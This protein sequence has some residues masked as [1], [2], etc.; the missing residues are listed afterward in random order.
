MTKD[1]EL[2]ESL[3]KGSDEVMDSI[4][5]A[6]RESNRERA[7]ELM[8]ESSPKIAI[9]G[10][11][12]IPDIIKTTDQNRIK[13]LK[14]KLEGQLQSNARLTEEV[15]KLNAKISD[16]EKV[17]EELEEMFD[18]LYAGAVQAVN[19]T[20]HINFKRRSKHALEQLKNFYEGKD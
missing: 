5:R 17:I 8:P 1:D 20:A 10:S 7:K 13:V 11:Q 2:K 9:I 12:N 15:W 6:V 4:N 3:K 14:E 16:R 18:T 19:Y